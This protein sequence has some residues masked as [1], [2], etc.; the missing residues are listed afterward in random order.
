MHTC[1]HTDTHTHTQPFY[2]SVDF[3]RDNLGVLVVPEGT[4]HHL[5]DFLLQNEDITGRHTNNPDGLPP[6]PE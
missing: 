6:H 3:V 1:I 4:F 2:S 5:L